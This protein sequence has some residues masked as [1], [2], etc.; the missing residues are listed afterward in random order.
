[1][2]PS[3]LENFSFHKAIQVR[4][5]DLDP[6]QHVNNAVYFSYFE[7]A[8]GF[9]MIESSPTWDWSKHMFVIASASADF[10]REVKF[11]REEP[12]IWVRTSR[13][14]NK[15]FDCEYAITTDGKDGVPILHSLGKTVQVMYD[16]QSRKPTSVPDWLREE[17]MA[18]E[19]DGTVN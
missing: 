3:P 14:G 19:K 2:Q 12:T 17:L 16:T 8:R 7:Y 9:Y 18:F 15:S 13:I 5:A 10:Y 6:L 1:M 4:W 11:A